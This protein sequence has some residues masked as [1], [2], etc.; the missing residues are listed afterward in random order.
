VSH[1]TLLLDHTTLALAA[2]VL[3]I[4][5]LHNSSTN[6]STY[7]YARTAHSNASSRAAAPGTRTSWG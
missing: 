1:E 4:Q 6:S 7:A 5:Q 3:F 2:V